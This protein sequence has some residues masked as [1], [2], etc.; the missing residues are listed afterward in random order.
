MPLTPFHTLTLFWVYLR[1]PKSVDPYALVLSTAL[2]DIDA[3]AGIIMHRTHGV[4]HSYLGASLFAVL[5]ALS[6]YFLEY[7][8]KAFFNRVLNVFRLP[9]HT[10]YRFRTILLTA[11]FGGLIHVFLD[12]FTH[13]SFPQIFFPFVISENP[14]WIGFDSARII[15]AIVALFS[16]YSLALWLGR[17]ITQSIKY[18]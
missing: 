2:I 5:L 16:I 10:P 14:F 18:E 1:Y 11:L 12:S 13:L 4:W 8:R 17:I 15:Y 3:A 7:K 6:L 9:A